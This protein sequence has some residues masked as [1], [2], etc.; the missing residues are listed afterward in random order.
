[1]VALT[2]INFTFRFLFQFVF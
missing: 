2:S 1:M